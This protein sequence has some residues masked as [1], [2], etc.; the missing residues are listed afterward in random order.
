MYRIDSI[1]KVIFLIG[2]VIGSVIRKIY[3][4][5]SRHTKAVRKRKSALDTVLVSLAGVGLA[6]PLVYL[7]TPWLD[8]ANY[9]LPSRLS[10]IGTAIFTGAILLL[11]RSHVD[12]GRNWSAAL[13]IHS[14][15]TLITHGVYRHIRQPMY[16]AHLLWAIGQA[17]LLSNWLAG[18]IFLVT[19][20][21]L[22]MFRV[23][24]EEQLMLDQFGDEYREYM[25]QT[26]RMFPRFCKLHI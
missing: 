13:R 17:L 24:K 6:T 11:W 2:L 20:I 4:A 19:F 22:Y 10:W 14:E 23:P 12:L 26:G 21:P 8:F 25:T 9:N 7:F 16:A 5:P 15:H 1:F 3:T 18:W